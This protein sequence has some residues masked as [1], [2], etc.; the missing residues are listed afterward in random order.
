MQ[1]GERTT[2]HLIVFAPAASSWKGLTKDAIVE[3]VNKGGNVLYAASAESG[4]PAKEI[5]S[6]FGLTLRSKVQDHFHFDVKLSE[7]D[8]AVFWSNA[9][10]EAAAPVVGST[11][12]K[13]GSPVLFSGTGQVHS[14]ENALVF[15]VLKAM[16]TASLD[17]K[18][19]T[20]GSSI[21]LVSASQA[22]NNARF[23]FSGSLAMFSDAYLKAPVESL[24][25]AL[26]K[27]SGNA[28][29]VRALT[30]WVFQEKSV[31]RVKS[32]A[33]HKAGETEKPPLYRIKDELVYAIAIEEY[34]PS[35]KWQPFKLPAGDEIQLELQML[36]PYVRVN[37]V[38]H[39]KT[40]GTFVAPKDTRIPDVYGV[41]T[42]KVVYKRRGWSY[43]VEQE[44]V[45]VVPFRHNEYPRFLTAAYPYY[46][47]MIS[48]IVGFLLFSLVHVFHKDVKAVSPE[49]KAK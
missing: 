16:S 4:T 49:K 22:R 26:P 43:V 2:D 31:L 15:P 48:M 8:H 7:R 42:F 9:V 29:F 3:F 5:A 10:P 30:E 32:V 34:T 28:A 44:E 45:S 47:S 13:D 18:S 33:H 25:T 19:N 14:E 35:G 46:A 40:A 27:K 24:D 1:F 6:Q 21:S 37:M 20:L 38:P 36:D 39:N 11:F 23:V 41:F 12:I 17:K